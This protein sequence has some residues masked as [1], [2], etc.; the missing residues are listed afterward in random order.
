MLDKKK[1]LFEKWPMQDP[2]NTFMDQNFDGAIDAEKAVANSGLMIGNGVNCQHGLGFPTEVGKPIL[3]IG[4]NLVCVPGL[5]YKSM[6]PAQIALAKHQS[7]M[8]NLAEHPLNN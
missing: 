7:K 2:H 1:K 5:N 6:L 3:N 4:G 8:K